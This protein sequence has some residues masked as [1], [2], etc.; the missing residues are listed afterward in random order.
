MKFLR[1]IFLL[2]FVTSLFWPSVAKAES[3]LDSLESILPFANDIQRAELLNGIAILVRNTDSTKAGNYAKQALALSSKIDFCKGAASAHVIIGLLYMDRGQY[4]LAKQYC[5]KGLSSGL[6][7]KE[8]YSVALAY[9]GL[10]DLSFRKKDYLK[11]LRFYFS[12]LKLSKQ[13][14]DYRRI[15]NTLKNIGSIYVVLND[16]NRSETYLLQALDLYKQ[17]KDQT[18]QAV[19]ANYLADV[20]RL[21]GYDLKALYHYLVAL[22]IYRESGSAFDVAAVLNNI[23]AVF[24]N[25][26]QFKKALPYL[27]ES[28]LID[29]T[30]NDK[31]SLVKVLGSLAKAYYHLN[32]KDSA[33]DL[34]TRAVLIAENFNYQ[35][36]QLYAVEILSKLYTDAG[37]QTRASKYEQ[38]YQLLKARQAQ[39]E[40]QSQVLTKSMEESDVPVNQAM[41]L[42]DP[43]QIV[44]ADNPYRMLSIGLAFALLLLT[45]LF[46]VFRKNFG[47]IK[48]PKPIVKK[49]VSI[50]FYRE[51]NSAIHVLKGMSQ[52]A[53]ESKN[54]EGLK[55]N[56]SAVKL[57]TD[58]LVFLVDN[59]NTLQ[60]IESG[61]LRLNKEQFSLIGFLENLFVSIDAKAKVKQNDFR[62]MV[63]AGVPEWIKFDKGKLSMVLLNL[64]NNAIRFSNGSTIEVEVK[65]IARKKIGNQNYSK[66]EIKISDE[67]PGI[68]KEIIDLVSQN[69]YNKLPHGKGLKIVHALMHSLGG[70]FKLTSIKGQG[71]M[72]KIQFEV[73]E[74]EAPLT[75]ASSKSLKKLNKLILVAD[76]NIMNQKFLEKVLVDTG[77]QCECVSNG[78]EVLDAMSQKQYDMLLLDVYMPIL[79]GIETCKRIRSDQYFKRH[80]KVPIV[81]LTANTQSKIKK[82][83]QDVGMNQVLN[84][85]F[86]KEQLLHIVNELL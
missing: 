1:F 75:Y 29:M 11:S 26:N 57:A 47:S 21:K 62:Q 60:D 78:A 40:Q 53:M 44:L 9:N 12:A 54:M 51:L 31:K 32:K 5:L 8:P 65:L 33:M 63:Y 80:N 73:E 25:R 27:Q 37:D 82:K 81:G 3:E 39:D 71:V 38:A 34:A 28:Q 7:C 17:L 22:E 48:S 13:L 35:S 2:L 56:L 59:L 77:Y 79:D 10:G 74:V 23:G 43:E 61:A 18:N 4:L 68:K 72:A 58:E 46:L 16:A 69:E 49:A 41:Q 66:I 55:E 85:P 6:T 20:Y 70:Q 14:N 19:I 52:L 84:K 42:E 83:C 50:D 45:V 76:D 36:E 67:G 15:A 64:F 30:M 24:L 86:N